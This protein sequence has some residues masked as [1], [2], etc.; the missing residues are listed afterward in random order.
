LVDDSLFAG[1]DPKIQSNSHGL[2]RVYVHFCGAISDTLSVWPRHFHE[3]AGPS[4]AKM[5]EV[6][7]GVW[8]LAVCSR[9][10]IA[11]AAP[12]GKKSGAGLASP[13]VSSKLCRILKIR[14]S[15]NYASFRTPI[16]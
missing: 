10:E 13:K 6:V 3:Q 2:H 8:F 4:I 7:A 5:Q 12:W 1:R 14:S 15:A 11:L 16:S 9:N